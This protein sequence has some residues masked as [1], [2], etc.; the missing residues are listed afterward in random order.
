MSANEFARPVSLD[1]IGEVARTV[2]IAAE[3]AERAALAV[4]F[5]LES[6]DRLEAKIAIRRE[7]EIVHAAG[8]LR[9]DLVQACVVTGDPLP[10]SLDQP[11]VLRFVHEDA[12]AEQEEVELAEEDCDT[13]AYAGGTVDLGEAVAETMALALDPF[14]RG[15]NADAALREAGVKSEEEASAEASPFAALKGLLKK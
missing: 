2:A 1:T 5:T 11:F 14:P 3:P 6:L 13:L 15:P 10:V 9:A 12:L 8:R 4:R 7:G